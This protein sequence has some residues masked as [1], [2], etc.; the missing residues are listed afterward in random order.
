MA[1][2]K[3]ILY[4]PKTLS[5]GNHPV[6]LRITNDRKRKY[7]T[8]GEGKSGYHCAKDQ[9]DPVRNRFKRNYPDYK[10]KNQVLDD[11]EA[12]AKRILT[13][14]EFEDVSFSIDKFKREFFKSLKNPPL[15]KYYDQEIARLKTTGKIS[16][17]NAFNDSKQSL[18]KFSKNENLKFTDINF[19]FLKAYESHEL[20]QGHGINTISIYLR[21]LRTLFNLSIKNSDTNEKDYPFKNRTN[22]NGYPLGKL[23]QE[24]N[25]RPITKEEIF[26]IRD[27]ELPEDSVLFHD[28][29]YFMFCY[30][31]RGLNFLD[32]AFLKWENIA[33][34]RL[35]YTRRKTNVELSI[36]IPAQALAIIEY[37]RNYHNS[38]YI[39]PIFNDYHSDPQKKHTR[40]KTAEK[41]LNSS[42]TTIAKE[43]K[44]ATRITTY[45]ARHTWANVMQTA[46]VHPQ[47]IQKGLGQS[48]LHSTIHYL[49]K[50]GDSEIDEASKLAI[51]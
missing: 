11:K 7:F 43:L 20:S 26:K 32:M 39:F 47:K 50:F 42:M 30:Y 13:R 34:G 22:P 9:W 16:Y 17:A 40:I 33:A 49:S 45:T 44:L 29:N 19:R 3:I 2:A 24:P 6:V 38:E 21:C 5:Q 28:R 51:S 37:Y 10:L 12:E 31:C 15:F 25:P 41:R 27:H 48:S 14:F 1:D 36:E 46:G 4:T 18:L 23:K 8:I 35:I